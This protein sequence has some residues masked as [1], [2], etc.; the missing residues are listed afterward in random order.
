LQF[1]ALSGGFS[2]TCGISLGKIYCWGEGR[3]G[4]PGA[5]G[6]TDRRIPQIVDSEDAALFRDVS[7]SGRTHAC[8]IT[9]A[10]G[11]YCWGR[12]LKGQL[13]PGSTGFTMVPIRVPAPD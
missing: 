6:L 12:G 2:T 5:G 13:G 3:N 10:G 8:A 4:I 7:S 11:V 1:T 9:F